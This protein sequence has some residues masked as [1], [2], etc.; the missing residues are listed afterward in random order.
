[1]AAF[2]SL[3]TRATTYTR[4][5]VCYKSLVVSTHQYTRI[6]ISPSIAMGI[7]GF[8][9]RVPITNP[10]SS[11]NPPQWMCVGT[12]LYTLVY[13]SIAAFPLPLDRFLSKDRDLFF[14]AGG[15]VEDKS[16]E[17][18]IL[19]LNYTH[20]QSIRSAPYHHL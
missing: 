14:E 16:P 8:G 15:G 18:I 7:L 10:K 5:V 3:P 12:R 20:I 11:S 4:C 19:L 13:K 2:L 17:N 6:S 9:I 1:M